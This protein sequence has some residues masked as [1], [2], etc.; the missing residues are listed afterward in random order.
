LITA[1]G[2]VMAGLLYVV[3]LSTLLPW[4]HEALETLVR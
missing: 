1:T 4:M 2:V 3:C